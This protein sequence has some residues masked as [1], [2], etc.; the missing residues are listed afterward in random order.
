VSTGFFNDLNILTKWEARK[1]KS[2][3]SLKSLFKKCFLM[4]VLISVLGKNK[5]KGLGVGY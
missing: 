3:H 4:S 5:N 2:I 1:L